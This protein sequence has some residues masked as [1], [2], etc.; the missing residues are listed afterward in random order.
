MIEMSKLALIIGSAIGGAGKTGSD[1]DARDMKAI[2]WNCG[3]P[4]KNVRT[5]INK[6]ASYDKIVDSIQ[7]LQ[8]KSDYSSTVIFLFSG[9]GG[10]GC[11][12]TSDNRLL[13]GRYLKSEFENIK[14]SRFFIWIGC[15]KSGSMI[16]YL[17]GNNRVITTACAEN[18]YAGDGHHNTL[19]GR[20]FIRNAMK[21]ELG[22][23][24]EDGKVSVEEAF[25]YTV[26][27]IHYQH[28]QISDNFN[29]EFIL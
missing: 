23:F 28:P 15:C 8:S 27:K 19:F 24:N 3:Y 14:Y 2:L 20:L 17:Q 1:G 4:K 9:H 13:Y 16:P 10:N 5:L 12:L 22:D 7:W 21:E 26:N 25:Q 6:K 11:L 18:E 29:G